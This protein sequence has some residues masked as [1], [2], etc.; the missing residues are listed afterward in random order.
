MTTGPWSWERFPWLLE[1]HDCSSLITIVQ[2]AAQ[3]GCSEWAINRTLYAM[4]VRNTDCLY[5]LPAKTPDAY[6]FSSGRFDPALELSPYLRAMFTS[7]KNKGHKVAGTSNLYIRGSKSR[8]G[9]RS[10]PTGRLVLDEVDVME[11]DNIPLAMERTAGQT[12]KQIDMLSTPTR[13]GTGINLYYEKSTQEHFHFKC[14]C[15]S[16]WTEMLFPQCLE[17][18]GDNLNDPELHNSFYKCKEC[19]GKLPHQMTEKQGGFDRAKVDWLK[20]HMWV[21]SYSNRD[22]RGFTVSQMYSTTITPLEF[23][24]S[25]IRS[26]TNPSDEQEFYNSK[27]GL[28]HVVSGSQITDADIDK[29]IGG[30]RNGKSPADGFI[31]MGVDVGKFLHYE[32]CR[33]FPGQVI[34]DDAHFNT[35]VRVIKIGKAEHFEEL[36][37]LMAEWNILSCVVDANPERRLALQFA[38]RH[39]GRVKTCFYGNGISGKA[40]HVQQEVEHTVTVDRTSWLDMSLGRFRR[41][42][43]ISIPIDTPFEYREHLKA[44]V[45]VY[46]KD[47]EGN[48]VGRYDNGSYEDHYAHSRNYCEI[49]FGLAERFGKHTNIE[50]PQ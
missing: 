20:A 13:G 30:N 47:K 4:D 48:P 8:S 32:I 14:P 38:N 22:A 2:K 49:A 24:Q 36:D 7:T 45:R 34:G 37:R 6:D 16:K 10:I 46:K 42:G 43:S 31:C 12:F 1:M 23:A 3:M 26:L 19:G 18:T 9:L 15:C 25:Y 39:Y 41:D 11:Q 21:P 50:S 28:P 27:L 33:F 35:P 40:I 29:C 44:L 5:V 17:V